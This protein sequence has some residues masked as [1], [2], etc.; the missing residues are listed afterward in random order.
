MK[1][2]LEI[3][4]SIYPLSQALS[5][6]I[7]SRSE[8]IKVKRRSLLLQ[9]GQTSKTI[10]FIVKGSVRV[11]YLT[12]DGTEHTTWLLLENEL[13]ISVYSFFKG[14]P[15]FEYIEANEDCE[16]IAL[17]REHLDYLYKHFMEFN[18]I[19]R[20][21]TEAYYI[22][23]EEQANS[24]RTLGAKARYQELETSNPVL[25]QRFPLGHIASYLGITQE[26]LSRIRKQK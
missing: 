25:L 8:Q 14:K 23:N 11:Y 7:I 2:L 18:L 4:N 20:K 19:G 5:D 3:F 21:L 12:K 24:L 26:T 13:L 15:S 1:T 9:E 17:H 16:L 10:Y 6:Q 22:R